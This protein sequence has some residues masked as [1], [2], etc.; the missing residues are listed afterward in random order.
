MNYRLPDN[1]RYVMQIMG[2]AWNIKMYYFKNKK[3]KEKSR[4]EEVCNSTK[5]IFDWERRNFFKSF[6][7]Q[8]DAFT[9]WISGLNELKNLGPWNR[10]EKF[11]ILV[12]QGG[13]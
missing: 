3:K 9:V 12:R 8:T 7:K 4:K 1:I 5:S 11:R 6:A 10:I 13:M 2:T